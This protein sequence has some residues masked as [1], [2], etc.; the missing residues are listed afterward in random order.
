MDE[1]LEV[2]ALPSLVAASLPEAPDIE[3]RSVKFTMENM[4]SGLASGAMDIAISAGAV[5]SP[6]LICEKV[7]SDTLVVIGRAGHPLLKEGHITLKAYLGAGHISV[8]GSSGFPSE[9]AG[10]HPRWAEP[11]GAGAHTALHRR[12]HHR[13]ALRF[14]ADHAGVVRPRGEPGGAQHHRGTAQ[15]DSDRGLLH[16]LAHVVCQ[17]P[18]R[19]L[20]AR[21][22][23]AL[24]C[25][26]QLRRLFLDGS[27]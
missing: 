8:T 12:I 3:L 4:E 23:H 25:G 18:R 24:V 21:L 15:A 5:V 10:A 11:P 19:H 22:G 20:A 16:A 13:L 1:R 6:S 26:A 14:A 7:V 9:E 17:R 2:F 27:E